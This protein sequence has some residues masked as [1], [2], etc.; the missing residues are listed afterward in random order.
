MKNNEKDNNTDLTVNTMENTI[1][2]TSLSKKMK[3]FK[4]DTAHQHPQ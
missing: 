4:K 1:T 3:Y 2:K